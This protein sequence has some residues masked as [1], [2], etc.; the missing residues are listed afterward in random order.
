MLKA[1]NDLMW[2]LDIETGKFYRN[3]DGLRKVLG[4]RNNSDIGG[5]DQF[6]KRIHPA[7]RNKVESEF[8][9]ICGPGNERSFE[10]EY[11]FRKEDGSY[12]FVYDRAIAICNGDGHPKRIVGAA[13]NITERKR[14]EKEV[15][16]HELEKQKAINQATIDTQEKERTEIGRELHDNVNQVLTTTKLYLELAMS[17]HELKDELVAKSSANVISVINEI[18]QLSRSLMDAN[19][20]DLGLIDSLTDL[21]SNVNLTGK[22]RVS[23]FANKRMEPALSKTQQLTIYRIIQ[24][25]LN[26]AVRHSEASEVTVSLKNDRDLVELCVQDDGIGFDLGVIKKGAG[27]KNIENRVYL[28]NGTFSIYSKPG[29]GCKFIIKFPVSNY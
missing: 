3:A 13:Q 2:E 8:G 1:T 9:R 10:L 19:I 14:L 6:L 20:E 4:I 25:I 16:M 28:L 7:D 21:T 5:L 18:R 11:R 26:N 24:E 17:N 23:F 29:Q 22:L 27:L 15:L 12:S